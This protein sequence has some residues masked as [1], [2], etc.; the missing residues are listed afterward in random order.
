MLPSVAFRRFFIGHAQS[1]LVENADAKLNG[2]TAGLLGLYSTLHAG[3]ILDRYRDEFLTYND[4]VE[5]WRVRDEPRVHNI[6]F[7]PA[8]ATER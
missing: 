7:G 5:A 1:L 8:P 6:K 2:F 4:D 3:P